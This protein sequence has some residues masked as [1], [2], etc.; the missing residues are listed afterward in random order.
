MP[1]QQS[2]GSEQ[3]LPPQFPET[4]SSS[5][6]QVPPTATLPLNALTQAG[7]A[8]S[9]AWSVR[10]H[11][12][13]A[14]ASMQAPAALPSYWIRPALMLATSGSIF[15][16]LA[17]VQLATSGNE[18][19]RTSWLQTACSAFSARSAR[20]RSPKLWGPPRQPADRSETS[21]TG[22]RR[23]GMSDRSIGDTASQST[24]NPHAITA[25]IGPDPGRIDGGRDRCRNSTSC[26]AGRRGPRPGSA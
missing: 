3:D 8:A 26:P 25:R 9:S 2:T 18:P 12:R 7:G 5:M 10:L 20:G 11:P 15:H 14:R 17:A 22:N 19:H 4:Q 23:L 1:A 13:A 21:T 6:K 16:T 24:P